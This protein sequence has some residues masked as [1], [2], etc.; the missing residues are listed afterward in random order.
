MSIK[1]RLEA[2]EAD[3]TTLRVDAIVNAANS[4]L[5]GGGG[6]DGAIHRAA[7]PL[8]AEELED[9]DGCEP[10]N[11]VITFGYDLPASYIIHTVAPIFDP[12]QGIEA[13]ERI[14]RSCYA[15]AL[16]I[17]DG[18]DLLTVAFP[19]IGTGAY[20]WPFARAS[21]LALNEVVSHLKAGGKQTKITFC[22]F[23]APDRERYETLIASLDG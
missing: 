3:I 10:G 8:L 20:R 11:A 9:Y 22:C 5:K 15:N 1:E 13:Q 23:S 4:A 16:K 7:G 14:F 18:E 2:I 12:S 6:V 21:E 17:A 19:S